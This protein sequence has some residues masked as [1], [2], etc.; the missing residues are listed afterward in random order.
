VRS[1]G[2]R[3]PGL[4]AAAPVCCTGSLDGGRPPGDQVRSSADGISPPGIGPRD[5]GADRQ[6]SDLPGEEAGCCSRA[7]RMI[8]RNEPR[9]SAICRLGLISPAPGRIRAPA[10]ASCRAKRHP[11]TRSRPPGSGTGQEPLP[12]RGTEAT[13]GGSALDH[14]CEISPPP[15]GALPGTAPLIATC[16]SEFSMDE[17]RHDARPTYRRSAAGAA[18]ISHREGARRARAGSSTR[19]RPSAAPARWTAERHPEIE[20]APPQTGSLLR[21][22]DR[23]TEARD[24]KVLIRRVRKPAAARAHR[25]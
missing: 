4:D 9:R 1:R 19:R 11:R 8:W 2:E 13:A 15:A 16:R 6:G 3:A 18:R 5:R 21:G 14:P 10:A 20:R 17:R 12:R 25:A 22:S 23:E 24:G 7:P